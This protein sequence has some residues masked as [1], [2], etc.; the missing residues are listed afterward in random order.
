VSQPPPSGREFAED[1][2]ADIAAVAGDNLVGVYL[3]GSLALGC[4]NPARSDV[5]L[6]VV[7]RERLDR[8]ARHAVAELLL[9]RS[10]APHPIE[11]SFLTTEQ[12]NPW[13]H[14]TPFDFHFGES[15]RGRELLRAELRDAP[16]P[17]DQADP[18]LAGH[19]GLLRERGETLIGP[20]VAAVF[21]PVPDA[22]F[23]DSIRRDLTWIQHPET[24]MGGRIYGVLNACRVLA[25]VRGAGILSK[26]EAAEWALPELRPELRATAAE[27]L[28]AYRSGG[29][30]PLAPDRARAFVAAVVELIEREDV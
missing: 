11:I 23:A 2:A 16:T 17:D 10:N 14:P 15:A 22:D 25:Y 19:I 6:L 18:D 1:V 28:A 24:R 21:P 26:A 27:A 3:H 9:R 7:T 29:D 8:A 20:P 30:E 5:D 13:R 12:L 4:F